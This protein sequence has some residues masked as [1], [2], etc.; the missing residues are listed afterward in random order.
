MQL[1][2]NQKYKLKQFT[3][4][5]IAGII[6][7][8]LYTLVEDGWQAFNLINGTLA[9][10]FIGLVVASLELFVFSGKL[11]RISF[12]SIFIL[13]VGIYFLLAIGVTLTLFVVSRSLKFKLTTAQVF[14][15]TE[16][17]TYLLTDYHLVLVFCFLAIGIAVFTLQM[18][19]KLGMKDLLAL[20]TGKYRSPNKEKRIFMFISLGGS[21]QIIN[22]IG[23]L[24]YHN[25][26]NDFI[27]DI[28]SIIRIHRGEIVHYTE[29]EV[30]VVWELQTGL[31]HANCIR[32]YFEICH[33]IV[34][35]FEYYHTNYGLLPKPKCALHAGPVIKA[36]V[37]EIKSEIAFFGDV[38]NTTS[39]ILYEGIRKGI[40]I[41][42]SKNVIEILELP[43]HYILK[44]QGLFTPRGKLNQIKLYS[45]HLLNR[46]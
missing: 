26:I 34:G 30:V 3:T 32:T 33:K 37:G 20:I 46:D 25:L 41:M 17:Q 8:F 27:H 23:N 42:A 12:I 9:G 11:R 40:D 39:R 4:I 1:T 15:S 45:L 19:R 10:F 28:S 22:Q 21:E 38:V 5:A 35:H 24:K 44:E 31:K 2:I 16:F 43:V 18:S 7:G 36:E 6:T 14:Q 13:R 29:D